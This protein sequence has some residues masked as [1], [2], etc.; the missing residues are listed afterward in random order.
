WLG[1]TWGFRAMRGLSSELDQ[2]ES[3]ERESLSEEHPRE[4]LRLT[5]SLNRLLRSE[6]KQRE[7]YRHSLGDLAHSLKTPL[8]VLQGVGDQLAE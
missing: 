2:I 3:G 4:L 8:A 1:L 5:H 6:H 7:R